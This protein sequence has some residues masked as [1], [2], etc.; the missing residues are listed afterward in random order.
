MAPKAQSERRFKFGRNWR[1]FLTLLNDERIVAAQDSPLQTLELDAL[2]GMTFLNIGSGSGLSSLAARQSGARVHSFDFDH[3]SV[4][5]TAKLK[6]RYFP[7]DEQ[8]TVERASAL[9]EG[10]L[11]S[12]GNFDIVYSWGVLHHT[13]MMWEAIDNTHQRVAER[14]RLFYRDLQRPRGME[15]TLEV[16]KKDKQNVISLFAATICRFCRDSK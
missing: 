15:R 8:W 4:G 14:G 3:D 7:C 11:V 6:R 2:A 1:N 16:H 9:D 13:G 5:C 12:L 10:Y